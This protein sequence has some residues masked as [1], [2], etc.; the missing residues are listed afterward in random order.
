MYLYVSGYDNVVI[1][2]FCLPL[3]IS[4]T[5]TRISVFHHSIFF[6]HHFFVRRHKALDS[7]CLILVVV[8]FFLV[9]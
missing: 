3:L 9:C 2:W 7:Y 6:I 1:Q 8:D 5:I 4:V